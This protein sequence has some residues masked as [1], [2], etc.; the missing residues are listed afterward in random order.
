MSE[1]NAVI[2]VGEL[3]K[4]ARQLLEREFPL[5]WV[6]GEISNLARA[7]SG[8]MY[9]SLKD[10]LAQVRCVMFRS[11]AQAL[12]WR[13]ENGQQVEVRALV[14]LYE[15][16]GEFQLSVEGMRRGGLGRLFEAFA[17]LREQLGTD[18][19][20]AAER[21]KVLPRYPRAI[22]IVSSPQAAALRD[23]IAAIGRRAPHLPMVLYP[24]AVQGDGAATNIAMA[25]QAAATRKET[26]LILVVRGGGSIEDLWA[27]NEEVVA[28]A[29]AAC[30][31]PT[32]S[33][34]GHETDVTIADYVVDLR[35]ATPTAAAELVTQGWFEAAAEIAS[36]NTA[37]GR[38]AEYRLASAQQGLDMLAPRL[39]HPATHLRM[40]AGSLNLL[41][42]KMK[43]LVANLVGKR[44]VQLNQSALSLYRGMPRTE[45]HTSR[46]TLLS[47]RLNASLRRMQANRLGT[48]ERISGAL[49][50]LNPEAILA[51]GFAIVRDENGRLISD[52][53]GLTT[54]QSISLRIANGEIDAGILAIH[55][56]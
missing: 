12:P 14:S 49:T 6:A 4:R 31:L 10:E 30:S 39:I 25:L 18:G 13:L 5:Q 11:R 24:T 44:Q 43:A 55:P 21:K 1:G 46:I 54:G 17:R 26:D 20:F 33:G 23:V 56:A 41:D 42:S 38:A 40:E 7:T 22:G 28:R 36:L 9:F 37:L 32:V 48:I 2:P 15:A 19:L 16:R 35:T 8:H 53:N 34:I 47:Q 51:R 3:N 50:H 45:N 52:V 29:L 27:F